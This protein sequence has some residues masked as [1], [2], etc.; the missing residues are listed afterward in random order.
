MRRAATVRVVG[1]MQWIVYPTLVTVVLSVVLAT[2]VQVFG[3]HLPEPVL[4]LVLA[5][6]WPL[7]RPSMLAALVLFLLGLFT[8][9]LLAGQQP[10]GLWS[11]SLMAV[12]GVV[13]AARSL[14]AGQET[15]NLFVWYACC[16]CAAFLLT[17]LIVTM[18]VGNAP[19]LMA[20]LGQLVPTLLLF[21][22]SNWMIERFDDGDMRFR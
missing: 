18:K 11:L 20:L 14:L 5:F 8:D 4:P 19:S 22:I 3:L 9:L 12:Y 16:T 2:P 1:P 7:I 10:L 17:Y 13:L 15:L 21:P 6:A